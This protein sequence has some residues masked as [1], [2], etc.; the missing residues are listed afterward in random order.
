MTSTQEKKIEITVTPEGAV[1][2]KTAGFAGGSCRDATRDL[3][4]GRLPLVLG[5]EPCDG[6][7][8]RLNLRRRGLDGARVDD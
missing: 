1:S 3:C 8:M 7:F 6:L 5:A 4:G 2:I